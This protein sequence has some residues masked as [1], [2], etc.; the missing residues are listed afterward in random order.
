MKKNY[1]SLICLFFVPFFGCSQINPTV[2][3]IATEVE[4]YTEIAA[5]V[6][7]SRADLVQYKTPI[8]SAA[9]HV[10]LV[11]SNY[12]DSNATFEQVKILALEAVNSMGSLTADQ[13]RIVVLVISQVMDVTLSYAEKNYKDII[14][15]DPVKNTLL[16]T[17]AVANGLNKSCTTNN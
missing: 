12:N 10:S 5:T 13:K 15:K 7:F 2:E 4:R 3:Q 11:L 9:N 1:A 6:A 16:I 8:C 17:K 14:A